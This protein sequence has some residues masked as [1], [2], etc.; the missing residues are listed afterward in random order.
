MKTARPLIPAWLGYGL[1]FV[2]VC[3]VAGLAILMYREPETDSLLLS[4]GGVFVAALTIILGVLFWMQYQRDKASTSVEAVNPQLTGAYEQLASCDHELGLVRQLAVELASAISV[5][6]AIELT[7]RYVDQI[8]IFTVKSYL[9]YDP[10]IHGFQQL[11]YLTE[12]VS[13]KQIHA[14]TEAG[15][16]L[17]VENSPKEITKAAREC[18]LDV[19]VMEG[20]AKSTRTLNFPSTIVLPI[21]QSN[22]MAGVIVIASTQESAIRS[23]EALDSLKTKLSILAMAIQRVQSFLVDQRSRT[24]AVVESSSNGVLIFEDDGKTVTLTNGALLEM[25]GLKKGKVTTADLSVLFAGSVDLESKINEV[26]KKGN[27]IKLSNIQLGDRSFDIFLTPIFDYHEDVVAGAI[28]VNDIT[29]FVEVDRMKTEFVSIASHQL[30]TPLTSINWFVEMLLSGDVGPLKGLQREYLDEVLQGSRRM[31]SLVNDLL[32]VSRLETGRLKIEPTPTDLAEMIRGIIKEAEPLIGS[33]D[34]KLNFT[35]PTPALPSVN[36]DAGLLRQV[37]HNLVTN[38]I[39]YSSKPKS[40]V[41]VKLSANQGDEAG[42]I[43]A[44][45]DQ[46]IGIPESMKSKIFEKFFRAD[47]AIQMAADGSGLGLYIAKL[48]MDASG[49]K[50]WFDTIEGKGTTFFVQIPIS[51]MLEQGGDKGLIKQ[52]I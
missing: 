32:N 10:R 42:I 16:A 47:N 26:I 41:E 46:G 18:K 49:G 43:I 6:E 30:R 5:R 24:Q 7:N 48:V 15:R 36:I 29:H 33:K 9:I 3:V 39:R 37:I 2:L 12:P 52:T 34:V 45:T 4:W 21:G 1:F 51:G 40:S 25:T 17:L 20:D 11:A 31:A 27:R 35:E 22:Q 14:L 44:V 8:G 19:R 13:Q 28:I 38:A 23:A 50:I